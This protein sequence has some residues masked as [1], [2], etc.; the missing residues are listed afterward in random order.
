MPQ[1]TWSWLTTAALSGALLAACQPLPAAAPAQGS[2]AGGL[3]RALLQSAGEAALPA[4]A[5]SESNDWS[6]QR[7]GSWRAIKA[8]KAQRGRAAANGKRKLLAFPD[9]NAGWAGGLDLT[10]FGCSATDTVPNGPASTFHIQGPL[11]DMA[12]LLTQEGKFVKVKATDP[13]Q[14]DTL[15][16]GHSFSRTAVTLSPLTSYAYLVSD[17]GTFFI[18][19]VLN[20]KVLK[21]YSFAGGYGVAPHVDPIASAPN[22][23]LNHVYVPSN[24][25]KIHKITVAQQKFKGIYFQ[26]PTSYDVATTVTP[27]VGTRK[28]AAPAVVMNGVI[29]VGDQAGNMHAYDTANPA[30]SFSFGLGAPVDTAP[31]IETQDGSYTLTDPLGNPKSVPVGRPVYAFVTAGATAAWL[32]LHD[33]TVARSQALRIDDNDRARRYGYLLD[34][35][36]SMKGSTE[37]LAAVDGGNL[38][39]EA[40]NLPGYGA[41]WSHDAL[42]PAETGTRAENGQPAGGPVKSFIRWKAGA[43]HAP[44]SVI[45]KATL[46]LTAAVNGFCRVPEVRSADPYYFGT[47][48]PWASS[49]L[50][51][52]NQPRT[53]TDRLGLFLGGSTG[54]R[55]GNRRYTAGQ[56]AEWDVSAAFA[57][58]RSDY[59]LSLA[60]D[61]GGDAVLWPE[62][63]FATDNGMSAKRVEAIKFTNNPLNA[64]PSPARAKDA[65]P[66][67]TLQIAG[68]RLATPSIET[69]PIIDSTNKRVYVFYTNA[70]Y[71]LSFQSPGAF[72]DTVPGEKHTVFNL[73]SLGRSDGA[74]YAGQT[75]FVGN[76][77]APVVNADLSA[78]YS[79]DRYPE[80]AGA[81]TPASWRYSLNKMTLPLSPGADALTGSTP[82]FGGVTRPASNLLIIDRFTTARAGEGDLLF[83]LGNGKVYRYER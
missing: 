65:R 68:T 10:R 39:S 78:I 25:G 59:A 7:L 32:N 35:D 82:S 34:Y 71:Q 64:D 80:D 38:N 21:Q 47:A 63:G 37:V 56:A 27:L 5:E 1:P 8:E 73:T 49:M 16:L 60:Y 57:S 6:L 9:A 28:I 44:G 14:F 31:A 81:S 4:Y 55:F 26:G 83:G 48:T 53:G 41:P 18:V 23:G 46:T 77:T 67:L 75:L 30:A 62:G 24:D 12:F 2:A 19:D 50:T 74:T 70:L 69:P 33:G 79:L 43:A 52:A 45:N 17:D 29:H 15:D 20:M 11:T 3:Q 61:A 13:S 40:A 54:G 72:S 22:D 51:I 36:F 42:V 58:P 76:G 66:L